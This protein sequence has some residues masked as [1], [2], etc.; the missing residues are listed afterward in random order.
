[1][2]PKKGCAKKF[3]KTTGIEIQS[4]YRVGDRKILIEVIAIKYLPSK[5]YI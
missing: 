3:I 4:Q 2:N 5:K 1:M